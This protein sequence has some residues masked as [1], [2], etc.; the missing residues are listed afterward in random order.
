MLEP[1]KFF[2][3]CFIKLESEIQLTTPFF[4]TKY[5]ADFVFGPEH[6]NDE[7]KIK[8]NIKF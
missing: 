8:Q 4:R 7:A 2:Y 5:D 1:K 6:D 3:F